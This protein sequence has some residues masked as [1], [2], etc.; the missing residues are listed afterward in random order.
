MI[1][2]PP[3]STLFPY[4]TLFRSHAIHLR[5]C[6][7]FVSAV[8]GPSFA[9]ASTG[10]RPQSEAFRTARRARDEPAGDQNA[11]GL[12]VRVGSD[13]TPCGRRAAPLWVRGGGE[14]HRVQFSLH[15]PAKL[16]AR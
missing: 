5:V 8:G 12:S 3:R 6:D 2:R 14:S 7:H 10:D 9:E 15:G 16:P 13:S 1:R 11:V 4:T